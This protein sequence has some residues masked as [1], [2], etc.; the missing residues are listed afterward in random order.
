LTKKKYYPIL[1]KHKKPVYKFVEFDFSKTRVVRKVDIKD[2]WPLTGID[3][4]TVYH[5]TVDV[6]IG[7]A[8]RQETGITC[9]DSIG[10]VSYSLNGIAKESTGYPFPYEAGICKRDEHGNFMDI[11]VLK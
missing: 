1:N 11:E 5:F 9:Y 3:E 10:E 2:R 8:V 6:V 7:S 4:V